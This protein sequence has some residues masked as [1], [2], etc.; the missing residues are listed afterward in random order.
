MHVSLAQAGD[1]IHAGRFRYVRV[2]DTARPFGGEWRVI[3]GS[4]GTSAVVIRLNANAEVTL[5][6]RPCPRKLTPEQLYGLIAETARTVGYLEAVCAD[7]ED[8]I[9]VQGFEGNPFAREDSW[10]DL[11]EQ[12][13][14]LGDLMAQAGI[15]PVAA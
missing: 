8:G 4:A 10:L 5:V 3:T 14:K 11:M 12:R 2:E 1:L 15:A 7:L 13:A 9:E 6:Q